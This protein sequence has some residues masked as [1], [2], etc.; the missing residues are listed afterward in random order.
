M[1]TLVGLQCHLLD[2]LELLLAQLVHLTS[3]DS[4]GLSSAVDA[5]SLKYNSNRIELFNESELY[6]DRYHDVSVVLQELVRVE[7]DD[8]RLVRLGNV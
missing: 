2:R 7:S 3:E 8:L 6:L 4:L 1:I 5:I